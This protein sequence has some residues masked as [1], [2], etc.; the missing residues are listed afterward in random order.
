M[1]EIQ[2]TLLNGAKQD[3]DLSDV[4]DAVTISFP[5]P[6]GSS[7]SIC[8][9]SNPLETVAKYKEDSEDSKGTTEHNKLITKGSC[10]LGH[11]DQGLP[12][13]L[14][15][16]T[17]DSVDEASKTL[18]CRCPSLGYFGAEYSYFPPVVDQ[19]PSDDSEAPGA[20]PDAKTTKE[21]F[22]TSSGDPTSGG[23][24]IFWVALAASILVVLLVLIVTGAFVI[25]KRKGLTKYAPVAQKKRP[26]KKDI[27]MQEMIQRDD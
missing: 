25:I 6:S 1:S 8:P 3:L 21:S 26:I 19:P 16:C 23:S 18:K 7:P 4:Q 22:E 10:V 11:L 2:F 17:T 12:R 15:T 20:S 24:S 27:E 9:S 13:W 14:H 5:G